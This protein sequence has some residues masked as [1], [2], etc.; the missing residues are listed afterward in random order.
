VGKRTARLV[1]L[2]L[3]LGFC[4]TPRPST[5]KEAP[6]AVYEAAAERRGWAVRAP[7]DDDWDP[8]W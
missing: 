2:A 5:A 3:A 4:P 8:G 1:A 7:N 6:R